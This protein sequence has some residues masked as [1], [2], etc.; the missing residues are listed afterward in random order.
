MEFLNPTTIIHTLG[1][2][3]VFFAV[4]A[5]T[6]LFFGFILPGDSLLFA[7]GV[8]ASQ[9]YISLPL[10]IGLVIVAAI[11]GDLVGYFT[12]YKYGVKIFRKQNSLFFDQSYIE[13]SEK[14]YAKYGKIT[15]VLARYTPI[16]RTFAP[17]L[18]G[19]GKMH[20]RTFL[21][22][23]ISGALLWGFSVILFGYYL[24]KQFS[25]AEK[26]ILPGVILAVIVST[27]PL[28]LRTLYR[29]YT[30]RKNKN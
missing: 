4:F 12:G 8:L 27:V 5:E 13:R 29:A 6:G 10:Y 3:G 2:L 9:G 17:I 11:L 26:Y 20:Y 18:A 19:V 25:G 7:I 15:L 30:R 23:N 22:W 24:G 21:F 16:V 14:F 1:V 28:I